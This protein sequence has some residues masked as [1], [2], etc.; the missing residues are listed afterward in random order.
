MTTASALG[1]APHLIGDQTMTITD[2]QIEALMS[3]AGAAGDSVQVAVCLAA[4]GHDGPEAGDGYGGPMSKPDARAEC[5]RV[6]AEA[7]LAACDD[8]TREAQDDGL[9]D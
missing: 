6:I 8:L 3:V 4:L 9:Y 7:R 2:E 1:E 5:A